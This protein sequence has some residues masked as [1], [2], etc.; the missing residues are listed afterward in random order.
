M[1]VCYITVMPSI[2]IAA[3]LLLLSTSVLTLSLNEGRI[4]VNE[5]INSYTFFRN[6]LLKLL[7]PKLYSSDANNRIVG[8]DRAELGQ[9]PYIVSIRKYADSG[10]AVRSS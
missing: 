10:L 4:K 2:N 8:G 7:E 1:I 6:Q 5:L 9:F 3:I